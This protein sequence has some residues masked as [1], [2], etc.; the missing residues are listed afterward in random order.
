MTNRSLGARLEVEQR[1]TT[2]LRWRGGADAQL[3]AYRIRLTAQGPGEPVVPASANPPPTNFTA[4]VHSDL[5]WHVAKRVELVPGARFNVFA[6][7]RHRESP[8][9]GRKKTL[10]P[11][12]DPRLATRVTV[13]PGAAWLASFG[14]SH[15]YPSLRLG[16]IPAPIVSVPGFPFENQQLQTAMQGS[17]GFEVALP[18]DLVLS[19]TGFYSVFWGLTDL[20]ASCFQHLPGD[21]PEPMPNDAVPPYICP[22]N[23]PVRGNAYGV[24]LLL[25]RSFSK[26]LSGWLSYTLS[27][28]TREA[29]FIKADGTDE[30][31]TVASEFDR[32]H[33]LNAVL[34]FALGRGWRVGS[35]LLF[36]TGTPYSQ[37]DG[38][39][40]VPPYNAYRNPAFYRVDFRL[41]KRW[42]LGKDASIAF[43]LEGQ[44]VTL[45][46]EVS[47]LG[48]DCEG[49]GGPMVQ[50]ETTCK[51]STVGPLTIPSVGVEAFF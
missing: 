51:Q 29:H 39:F 20:S 8:S 22:N 32:T 25:R 27:R 1:V 13:A 5:V 28:S 15:Q 6:S 21:E 35:R 19:A 40:P 4:G 10:L 9:T 50:G 7:S 43:V 17:Q 26:R 11:A 47:G 46:K 33:V 31:A 49:K 41:E 23:E 16:D 48:L 34:S 37:L 14:L 18:A 30:L 44:N 36:F 24:E 2:A 3:D 45:S 12:I 38:S 42:R